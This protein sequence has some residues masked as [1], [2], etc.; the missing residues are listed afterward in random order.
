[1]P[2]AREF[3]VKG[4]VTFYVEASFPASGTQQAEE[5]FSELMDRLR[6][7]GKIRFRRSCRHIEPIVVL[8]APEEVEVERI[9]DER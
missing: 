6:G 8:G 7:P 3:T 5:R 4:R 2:K 1:M 9:E